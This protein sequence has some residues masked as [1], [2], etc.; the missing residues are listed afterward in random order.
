MSENEF[1]ADAFAAATG[2]IQR[3]CHGGPGKTFFERIPKL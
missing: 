1:D 2:E 3:L